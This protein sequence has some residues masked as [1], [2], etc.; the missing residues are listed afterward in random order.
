[1]SCIVRNK[2]NSGSFGDVYKIECKDKENYAL[3]IIDN[4]IYGIR[5]ITEI[6]IL[7]FLR[8]SYLMHSHQ[9]EVDVKTRITK[10]LMPLA[11]CDFRNSISK[12]FK[13]KE[14]NASTSK[15]KG[16]LWQLV[17]AVAFLHTQ[18]IIHGDIKPSNVLLYKNMV[19]LSDFSL[20]VIQLNPENRIQDKDAYTQH[21]RPPEVWQEKGYS[22]KAD[23]W[24]LGC[25][26]HEIMYNVK[27]SAYFP[28]E[29]LESESNKEFQSLLRNMLNIEEKS[30]YDIW[31]VM[32][33]KYFEEY[34]KS[35][36]D[37]I[38][39]YPSENLN[40]V[41][42]I[43][44]RLKKYLSSYNYNIPE[45]VFE[46]IANKLCNRNLSR[47]YYIYLDETFYENEI[48]VINILWEK[49]INIFN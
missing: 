45:Y 22:Y 9:F 44:D 41:E 15:L 19:K 32:K 23:V 48:K 11:S 36:D 6:L 21:Y 26:L 34:Y 47:S 3:K 46:I 14:F 5:C 49:N 40:S 24:A 30:R 28:S 12:M 18:G 8:Y 42:N 10:I 25:T 16:L 35:F 31:D 4:G 33:S 38:L 13:G 27:Y 2:I 20:S 7:L 29:Y 17:C 1:M 39:S 43:K 37:F